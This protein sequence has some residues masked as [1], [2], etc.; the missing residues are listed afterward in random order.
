MAQAG[1]CCPCPSSR[2]GTCQINAEHTLVLSTSGRAIV[3]PAVSGPGA[4]RLARGIWLHSVPECMVQKMGGRVQ[5]E[6]QRIKD[7]RK[8]LLRLQRHEHRRQ[9]SQHLGDECIG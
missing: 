7:D 4:L 1:L 8:L 9:E 6:C 3:V 2:S 5:Q